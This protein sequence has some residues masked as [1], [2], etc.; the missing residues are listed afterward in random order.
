MNSLNLY[1]EGREEI[2]EMG[3]VPSETST[4]TDVHGMLSHDEY[5]KAKI[6]VP[7]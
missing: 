6:T 3:K 5:H 1:K 7:I 4:I 2:L